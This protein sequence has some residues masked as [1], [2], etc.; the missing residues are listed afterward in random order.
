MKTLSGSTRIR[1]PTWKVPALSHSHTVEACERLSG[2]SV[3][4]LA[5]TT[6]AAANEPRTDAVAR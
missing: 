1:R 2:D 5:S 3:Q 6:T 4:S